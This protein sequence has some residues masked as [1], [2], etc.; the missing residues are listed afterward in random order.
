M[1]CSLINCSIC[2]KE[3]DKLNNFILYYP[4]AECKS[5]HIHVRYLCKKCVPLY[6]KFQTFCIL[7]GNKGKMAQK[8]SSKTNDNIIYWVLCGNKCLAE[9][10][11][12]VYTNEV[13]ATCENCRHHICEIKHKDKPP[14]FKC[15]ACKETD[16]NISCPR[17][18]IVKYCCEE[19]RVADWIKHNFYCKKIE[20]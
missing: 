9:F 11:K 4:P 15:Q 6:P 3:L 1:E 18:K 13:I 12:S 14:T 16:A 2:Y 5:D 8:T 20:F 19:C 17:C 10:I 7:C